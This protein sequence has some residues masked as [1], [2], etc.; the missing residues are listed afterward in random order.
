M[1]GRPGGNVRLPLLPM[2][3]SL[4]QEMTIIIENTRKS[5]NSIL[6]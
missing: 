3:D 6:N 2:D 1:Q 5:L 4:K